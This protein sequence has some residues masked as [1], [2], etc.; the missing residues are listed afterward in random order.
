MRGE[1]GSR[2]KGLKKKKG[3]QGRNSNVLL[4]S[5]ARA[6]RQ[7]WF[8]KGGARESEEDSGEARGGVAR[9]TAGMGRE[10]GQASFQ[11]GDGKGFWQARAPDKGH[12][13]GPARGCIRQ[14]KE[15]APGG[16]GRRGSPAHGARKARRRRAFGGRGGA[17]S[18]AAAGARSRCYPATRSLL[19]TG[20]AI[21]E[22]GV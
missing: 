22:G 11:Q 8:W 6:V 3:G 17:R 9:F 16:E 7:G 4:C 18:L 21:G 12:S 10:G 13:A 15:K 19:A 5:E 1:K 20:R 2:R 14:K